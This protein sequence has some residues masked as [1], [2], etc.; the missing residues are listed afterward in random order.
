MKAAENVNERKAVPVEISTPKKL[1]AD[2][3]H[4]EVVVEYVDSTCFGRN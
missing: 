4:P 2:Y 1:A 3:H